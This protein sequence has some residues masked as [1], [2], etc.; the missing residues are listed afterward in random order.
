MRIANKAL[1]KLTHN[2]PR[3]RITSPTTL[4]FPILRMLFIIKSVAIADDL[5]KLFP[6]IAICIPQLLNVSNK[7]KI[8]QVSVTTLLPQFY[9]I[10]SHTFRSLTLT[11]KFLLRYIWASCHILEQ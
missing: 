9:D 5:K 3:D 7:V 11:I 1:D 10:N 2:F 4:T 6:V 8:T